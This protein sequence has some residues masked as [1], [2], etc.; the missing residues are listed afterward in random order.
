MNIIN[1]IYLCEDIDHVSTIFGTARERPRWSLRATW[2]PRASCWWSMQQ[3]FETNGFTLD[4]LDEKGNFKPH[5][6]KFQSF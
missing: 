3:T 2:C 5:L 1:D 6:D 4:F